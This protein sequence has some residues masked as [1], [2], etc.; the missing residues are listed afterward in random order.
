M[1]YLSKRKFIE[2]ERSLTLL[3]L[4]L[5]PLITL[6]GTLGRSFNW[7]LDYIGEFK[8]QAAVISGILSLWCIIKQRWL[9]ML[10]Y[11]VFLIVNLLLIATHYHLSSSESILPE[12]SYEFK[13]LYQDLK[14]TSKNDLD[15]I[16]LQLSYSQANLILWTNVPADIY[17]NLNKIKNN[18]ILLN[19]TPNK[20]GKM[21]L[22]LADAPALNRG[23]IKGDS[24]A[25]VSLKIGERK[26]TIA[27]TH[28]DNP[29]NQKNYNLAKSK[30]SEI[31][32][33]AN[34]RDEPIILFG[35]FGASGWS[36]L[37]RDLEKSASLRT[38]G[39]I[40][41]TVNA[42]LPRLF[43]KPTDSI[44]AHPGIEIDDLEEDAS[45]KTNHLGISGTIRIAP[46][47]KEI[48]FYDLEPTIS[49]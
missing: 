5:I 25:W 6:I 30:I 34:S 42:K 39:K 9:E 41:L 14:N 20:E 40:L 29:W 48:E 23:L 18:F 19:Q 45:L 11:I 49:E 28:L 21:M 17:R 33:F 10:I 44:Y 8:L 38:E 24:G 47:V 36:Y 32:Q 46:I 31:S 1:G 35:G 37:L 22:I 2:R 7:Y 26:A 12:D 4:M 16:R 13:F 15:N 27:L 43:R 3:L